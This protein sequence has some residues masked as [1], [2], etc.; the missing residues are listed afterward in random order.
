M[1]ISRTQNPSGGDA[2]PA[3]VL[4]DGE[5]YS[6]PSC[7]SWFKP[8]GEISS[9]LHRDEDEALYINLDEASDDLALFTTRVFFSVGLNGPG[10]SQSITEVAIL[11]PLG[12]SQKNWATSTSGAHPRDLDY[13]T[14]TKP[15]STIDDVVW[16]TEDNTRLSFRFHG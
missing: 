14:T 6:R 8:L 2:F 7:P 12:H 1:S 5:I 3:V 10:L 4:P 13:A 11:Q 9:L 16:K 15:T